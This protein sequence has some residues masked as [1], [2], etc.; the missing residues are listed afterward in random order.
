MEGGVK[1]GTARKYSR[2]NCSRTSC[3]QLRRDAAAAVDC[4]DDGDDDVVL[5]SVRVVYVM[6]YVWVCEAAVVGC[7]ENG[8]GRVI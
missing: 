4:V 6:V 8:G 7:V 1:T 2:C 3:L 5:L